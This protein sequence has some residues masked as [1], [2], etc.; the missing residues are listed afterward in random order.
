MSERGKGSKRIKG[1][2]SD[3]TPTKAKRHGKV[4]KDAV[5]GITKPAIRRLARRAGVKRLAGNV[6]DEMRDILARFTQDVLRDSVSYT[7]HARRRT[8]TSK[9]VLAALKR[10]GRTVYTIES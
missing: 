10:Q 4:L 5:Q 8:V 7:E 1:E 3:A 6:Y 9:D 2:K